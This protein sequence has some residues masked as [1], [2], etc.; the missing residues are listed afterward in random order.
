MSNPH[1]EAGS[2]WKEIHGNE[3]RRASSVS[4]HGVE[5]ACGNCGQP[6]FLR[7]SQFTPYWEPAPGPQEKSGLEKVIRDRL[8]HYKEIDPNDSWLTLRVEDLNSLLRE[9]GL[10]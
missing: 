4:A 7:W 10:E 5:L 2:W 3:V 6:E 1:V 9:A 8:A